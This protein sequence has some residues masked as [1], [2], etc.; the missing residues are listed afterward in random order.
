M[1]ALRGALEGPLGKEV[2]RDAEDQERLCAMA[3][4]AQSQ[5]VVMELDLSSPPC[6]QYLSPSWKSLTKGMDPARLLDV[7][8][9]EIVGDDPPSVFE[10]ATISL[11]RD[12]TRTVEV[13]FLLAPAQCMS[14]A[15]AG[16]EPE[17]IMVVG[18]GMMMYDK[19]MNLPSRTL[20][21]L[22][23]EED[24]EADG[25]SI[26]GDGSHGTQVP[27]EAGEEH[28]V[29]KEGSGFQDLV[30]DQ[31][32][33]STQRDLEMERVLS[34]VE[35][36]PPLPP[37]TCRICDALIAPSWF[38]IHARLCLHVHKAESNVQMADDM[39]KEMRRGVQE[40]VKGRSSP[41]V[42][43]E[44][45][46][47]SLEKKD[48]MSEEDRSPL[49][50]LCYPSVSSS[51][52]SNPPLPP[53]SPASSLH[54]RPE[55]RWWKTERLKDGE[56]SS[57]NVTPPSPRPSRRGD[58]NHSWLGDP[59]S[60][61]WSPQRRKSSTDSMAGHSLL[62]TTSHDEN[63]RRASYKS[64]LKEKLSAKVEA[65]KKHWVRLMG[66]LRQD[67]RGS[68]SSQGWP[69]SEM[70][71]GEDMEV[72]QEGK[73]KEGGGRGGRA[74][75]GTLE[76][77]VK[78]PNRT[79]S[80][81]MKR[82][83]TS[84]SVGNEEASEA[85]PGISVRMSQTSTGTSNPSTPG[86]SLP[87][88]P[89]KSIPGT[90]T[91]SSPSTPPTS[92]PFFRYGARSGSTSRASPSGSAAMP[93]RRGRHGYSASVGYGTLN[94]AFD[95][96]GARDED[97]SGPIGAMSAVHLPQTPSGVDEEKKEERDEQVEDEEDKGY[98]DEGMTLKV[99]LDDQAS[100]GDMREK[101]LP[102][103]PFHQITS[104]PTSLSPGVI[105]SSPKAIAIGS[106]QTPLSTSSSAS[107]MP[108]GEKKEL[109]M[110]GSLGRVSRSHLAPPPPSTPPLPLPYL[111]S[112]SASPSKATH[113]VGGSRGHLRSSSMRADLEMMGVGRSGP[114]EFGGLGPGIRKP[115]MQSDPHGHR[116]RIAEQTKRRGIF[117]GKLLAAVDGALAL[118]ITDEEEGANQEGGGE[119]EFRKQMEERAKR[120]AKYHAP[121]AVSLIGDGLTPGGG[122]DPV[123]GHIGKDVQDWVRAKAEA[124]LS[125]QTY[126]EKMTEAEAE[127]LGEE[128]VARE[129]EG[130]GLGELEYSTAN[131]EHVGGGK[132]ADLKAF[133]L[134]SDEKRRSHSSG[135]FGVTKGTN[136]PLLATPSSSSSSHSTSTST[137]SSSPRP[138]VTPLHLTTSSL[139]AN[140]SMGPGTPTSL[141]GLPYLTAGS[142]GSSSA[143]GK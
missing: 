142:T 60:R 42:T 105:S 83:D 74:R 37:Q 122:E 31:G 30:S 16:A 1:A 11:L 101:S 94:Q 96:G 38:E 125:Y 138:M 29:V 93:G 61:T 7:E 80:R 82:S 119:D 73:K 84:K 58:S 88:T 40:L 8:A 121:M 48:A 99:P 59:T 124:V 55:K 75:S 56:D 118:S 36:P 19:E 62:S 128:R 77:L 89:G 5:N 111:S 33:K 98:S 63:G 26:M 129:N 13:K 107:E 102:D 34:Q 76:G 100:K 81:R 25:V 108:P 131:Q 17:E 18:K 117:L 78:G 133:T 69:G 50:T 126:T 139:M 44:G 66:F 22:R 97:E 21:V 135:Y 79:N 136:S 39:L 91:Q 116:S 51:A 27:P 110:G 14:G 104:T 127:A 95:M 54:I 12:E 15:Q 70:G 120:L 32:V 4:E 46:E 53:P 87:G 67:R 43:E 112:T 9:G 140:R 35:E 137:S 92:F 143:S 85:F 68:T 134:G 103:L 24:D 113:V 64:A 141:P 109:T 6:I 115:K 106:G 10:E 3:E 132:E 130:Q 47:K 72:D 86:S 71:R 45:M 2:P 49:P 65:Q 114:M 28:M 20:W 23:P 52:Q 41:G 90:P 57:E 123:L